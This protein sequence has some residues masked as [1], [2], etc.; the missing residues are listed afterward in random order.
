MFVKV[1]VL[2]AQSCATLWD[3]M[4][5][6]PPGSSVHGTLQARIPDKMACHALLQRIFPA[7]GLNLSLPHCRQILYCLS[8]QMVT[9]D[10]SPTLRHISGQIYNSKRYMCPYVHSSTIHNSQDMQTNQMSINR[11]TNK[12]DMVHIY[13]GILLS[14]KKNKAMPLQQHG[15]N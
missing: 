2:V 8:H 13:N 1:K 10:W 12:E 11:W 14:H 15:C 7:Q 9:G 4:D 6:S 3:F 5:Y